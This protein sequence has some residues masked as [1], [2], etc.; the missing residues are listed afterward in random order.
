LELGGKL[1]EGSKPARLF[2]LPNL[3]EHPFRAFGFPISHDTGVWA[4]GLLRDTQTNGWVQIEDIKETG[5][6][7]A[8]GFS[9]T[10]N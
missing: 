5:Y 2:E 7:V 3:W 8:P 1:P 10:P 6:S 9:G 4:S